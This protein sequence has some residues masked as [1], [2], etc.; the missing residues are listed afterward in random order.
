MDVVWLTSRIIN[1]K[2]QVTIDMGLQAVWAKIRENKGNGIGPC[3]DCPLRFPGWEGSAWDP[4]ILEPENISVVKTMVITEGPN[5][6]ADRTHLVSLANHPTFTFLYALFKGKFE[7]CGEKANVYWTHVRKCFINGRR[8]NKAIRCCRSYVKDEIQALKPQLIISVGGEALKKLFLKRKGLT[9][10][11][12]FKSQTDGVY[13]TLN[14]NGSKCEISV[15]P[16]P[17]GLSRFWNDPGEDT[18]H[19]LDEVVKKI[20]AILEDGIRLVSIFMPLPLSRGQANT[21]NL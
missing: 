10:T 12:A 18:P 7:P 20:E 14:L 19:I 5:R 9:L 13:D 1:F 15:V 11:E 17:S 8:G 16:H 3:S 4:L 21:F 2:N 6:E